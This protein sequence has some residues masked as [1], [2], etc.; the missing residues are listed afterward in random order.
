MGSLLHD[1]SVRW[2]VG[3]GA[4]SGQPARPD[5]DRRKLY[6]VAA[7]SSRSALRVGRVAPSDRSVQ[8]CRPGRRDRAAT[9]ACRLALVRPSTGPARGPSTTRTVRVRP[10]AST[11]LSV[12]TTGPARA[13]TG[14]SAPRAAPRSGGWLP[15]VGSAAG[16]TPG[17]SSRSPGRAEPV[18][19]GEDR[20]LGVGRR[21]ASGEVAA[22]PGSAAAVGVDGEAVVQDRVVEAVRGQFEPGPVAEVRAAVAA[23]VVRLGLRGRRRSAAK[24]EGSAT[25]ASNRVLVRP[26]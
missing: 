5:R 12:R 25:S 6:G 9:R 23:E 3:V 2:G 20:R 16:A 14:R 21:I 11:A 17:R 10:N 15:R 18:V 4:R 22:R 7:S 19:A 24:T 8:V 26:G 1:R 13:D